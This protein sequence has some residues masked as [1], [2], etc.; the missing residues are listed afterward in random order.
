[1]RDVQDGEKCEK[2]NELGRKKGCEGVEQE[3]GWWKKWIRDM[4]QKFVGS[5][6]RKYD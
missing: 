5:E 6:R 4:E 1:M 2:R 3:N